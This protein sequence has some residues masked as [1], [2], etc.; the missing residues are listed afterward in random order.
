MLSRVLIRT[1]VIGNYAKPGKQSF[2]RIK[3]LHST[4][5]RLGTVPTSINQIGKPVIHGTLG[6]QVR[7]VLPEYKRI[8]NSNGV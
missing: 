4:H 7:K 1:C 3:V 5:A 8:I 6:K 2:G